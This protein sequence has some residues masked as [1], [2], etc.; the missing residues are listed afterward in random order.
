MCRYVSVVFVFFLMIRRPPRSTRT[1]TRCP[2]TTLFRARVGPGPD[3]RVGQADRLHRAKAK[4]VDASRRHHL[5][6]QAAFEIRSEEHT[7]ELQS[8][9]RI[10]YAVFC[11][12]KKIQNR[13]NNNRNRVRIKTNRTLPTRQP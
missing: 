1:D 10:S 4:R 2:Y 9:M 12:K 13:H 11:L 5:D 6:R 3:V 8:L 7:S